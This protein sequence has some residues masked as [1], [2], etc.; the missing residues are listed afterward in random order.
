MSNGSSPTFHIP[1]KSRRSRRLCRGNGSPL[2]TVPQDLENL[3]LGVV[4][5]VVVFIT[6][7]FSFYQ[8]SKSDDL[9][10]SFK[11]MA[12]PKVSSRSQL[13]TINTGWT[14]VSPEKHSVV[15]KVPGERRVACALDAIPRTR[16][17]PSLG[18][19][20]RVGSLAPS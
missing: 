8:N 17:Y 11:N 10:K 7:C 15:D 3:Y 18:W 5:A 12:P 16:A 20:R 19:S 2:P 1:S 6:G 9:M 4:L 14:A 13:L